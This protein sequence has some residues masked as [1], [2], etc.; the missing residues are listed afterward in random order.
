ML[1]YPAPTVNGCAKETT[2]AEKYHAMVEKRLGNSRMKDFFDIWLL[3][4][5]FSFNGIALSE[6]LRD[7]FSAP[8]TPI[9]QYPAAL[10]TQFSDQPSTIAQWKSFRSRLP[11][12]ETCPCDMQD[13]SDK[14]STFLSP[15]AKSLL[16]NDAFDML[17]PPGGPWSPRVP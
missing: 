14:I 2:I 17:W 6:A 4:L 10:S 1:D 15:V 5:A 12:V 11:S 16:S 7:T 13:V 3:S 8:N 9:I